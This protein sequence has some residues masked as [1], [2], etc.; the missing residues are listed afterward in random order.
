MM[1]LATH[2]LVLY[3]SEDMNVP[4]LHF[5]TPT[6]GGFKYSPALRRLMG[7]LVTNLSYDHDAVVHI[8]DSSQIN[9]VSPNLRVTRYIF[10]ES[11][12]AK[13]GTTQERH[14]GTYNRRGPVVK[15]GFPMPDVPQ[16]LI[17]YFAA[18]RSK[19]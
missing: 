9:G 1:S 12:V 19:S 6:D 10:S 3:I 11:H 7:G 16:R 5:S 8:R 2:I 15:T 17:E 14:P 18:R 4:A 13:E